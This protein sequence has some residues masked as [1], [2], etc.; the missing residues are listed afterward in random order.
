MAV[1]LLCAERLSVDGELA[2]A[3]SVGVSP[4]DRVVRR[5]AGVL[6]CDVSVRLLVVRAQGV[7]C[8]LQ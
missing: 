1:I 7:L 5:V 6:G 3:D 2:F 8:L 4:G